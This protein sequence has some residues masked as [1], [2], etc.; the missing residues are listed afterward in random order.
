MPHVQVRSEKISM[1]YVVLEECF[2]SVHSRMGNLK[3]HI[4][5]DHLQWT[6]ENICNVCSKSFMCKYN[7]EK[8]IRYAHLMEKPYR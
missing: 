1:E 7:L 4:L 6:G 5:K 8:H 3:W 2:R